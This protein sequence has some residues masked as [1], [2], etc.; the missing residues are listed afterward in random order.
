[1]TSKT[2]TATERRL[3]F[4]PRPIM[5]TI[6]AMRVPICGPRTMV[7]NRPAPKAVVITVDLGNAGKR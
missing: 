7:I 4:L 1:M 5:D 2:A 3:G 6:Q